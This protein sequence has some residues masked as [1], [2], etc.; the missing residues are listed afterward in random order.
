MIEAFRLFFLIEP[1]IWF[2]EGLCFPRFHFSTSL[3]IPKWAMKFLLVNMY[4]HDPN[5]FP[6]DWHTHTHFSVAR[7]LSVAAGVHV[8]IASWIER[9]TKKCKERAHGVTFD[10]ETE[11]FYIISGREPGGLDYKIMGMWLLTRVVIEIYD[12]VRW[13][14]PPF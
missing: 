14:S 6:L 5:V 7:R 13:G 1:S 4:V 2:I 8:V 12:K 10:T 9:N 11:F 3:N